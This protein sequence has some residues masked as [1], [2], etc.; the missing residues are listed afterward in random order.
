MMRL[1]ASRVLFAARSTRTMATGK[2]IKFGDDVRTASIAR[3]ATRIA[4]AARIGATTGPMRSARMPPVVVPSTA[5]ASRAPP[6][7]WLTATSH[8]TSVA[9]L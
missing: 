8:P 6:A 9:V 2:E 5:H 7:L 4:A 3:G 1:R